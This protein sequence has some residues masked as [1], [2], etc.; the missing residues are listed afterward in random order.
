MLKTSQAKRSRLAS[1]DDK[2]R[3]RSCSESSAEPSCLARGL[4]EQVSKFWTE[5]SP[6]A[7]GV[8]TFVVEICTAP[9]FWELPSPEG[10]KK[11][12]E[13]QDFGMGAPDRGKEKGRLRKH[14]RL[15]EAPGGA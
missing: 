7:R 9:R 13:S 2:A 10:A 6:L 14:F 3:E 15:V 12:K 5:L 4:H 8:Q 1:Q 11:P